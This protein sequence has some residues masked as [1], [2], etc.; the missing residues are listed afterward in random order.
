[1][2]DFLE[3]DNDINKKNDMWMRE[4][5]KFIFLNISVNFTVKFSPLPLHSDFLKTLGKRAYKTVR[6]WESA[7]HRHLYSFFQDVFC[8]F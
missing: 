2:V 1:M 7:G 4:K 6:N 3:S 5:K 8:F